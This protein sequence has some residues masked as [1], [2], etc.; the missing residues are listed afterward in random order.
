MHPKKKYEWWWTG[1]YI[2]SFIWRRIHWF[3]SSYDISCCVLLFR[4]TRKYVGWLCSYRKGSLD[5]YS[6]AAPQGKSMRGNG[7]TTFILHVAQCKIFNQTNCVKITLIAKGSLESFY[8]RLGFQDIKIFAN[9]NWFPD[10][11]IKADIKKKLDKTRRKLASDE[12]EN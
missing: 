5:D 11:D 2:W 10:K 6:D 4:N 12:M 3:S 7:I 8:S 9:E 1:L